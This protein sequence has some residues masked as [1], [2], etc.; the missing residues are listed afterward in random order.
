MFRGIALINLHVNQLAI[1]EISHLHVMFQMTAIQR[2]SNQLYFR[3]CS[4]HISIEAIPK[5]L[6]NIDFNKM[7]ESSVQGYEFLMWTP[8]FVVIRNRS[9][10]EITLRKDGRMVIR[11]VASEL[12]ARQAAAEVM[13]F[14]LK[15]FG[16]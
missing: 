3:L 10:Q 11:K 13:S 14:V 7:K 5:K 4:D 6:I 9:G 2:D 8:H 12:V 1:R 15:D 16:V